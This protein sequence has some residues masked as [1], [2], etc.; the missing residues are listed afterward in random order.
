[1]TLQELGAKLEELE[2]GRKEAK[3]EL[4]SPKKSSAARGGVREG[5]GCPATEHVRDSARRFRGS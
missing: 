2:E 1:M 3:R 4:D 5:P